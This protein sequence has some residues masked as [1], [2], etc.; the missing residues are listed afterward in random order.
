[1]LFNRRRSTATGEPSP[2]DNR[3]LGALPEVAYL[4]LLPDLELIEVALGRVV[5]EPGSQLRHAYFPTTSIVSLLYVMNDGGSAE[6]AVVGNDGLIGM[7]LYLGG[8]TTASRAVVQNAGF[9]YQ[10]KVP[11]FL[12]EFQRHGELQLLLLR[13]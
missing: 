1:M 12:A 2:L 8:D 6:I 3:L 13:Y 10:I 11:P 5:Y 4:R 7:S 9:A